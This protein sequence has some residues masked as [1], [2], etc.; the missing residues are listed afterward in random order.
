MSKKIIGVTVGTTMNP[1]KI[2]TDKDLAAK[3]AKNTAD[4]TDLKEQVSDLRAL[5]VD[6]NEVAY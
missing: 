5:L 1:E 6:G 3:V 2:G 4:I